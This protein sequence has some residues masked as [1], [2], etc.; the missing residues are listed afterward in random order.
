MDEGIDDGIGEGMDEGG[1]SEALPL[2]E[3]VRV[4]VRVRVSANPN[5]N[6]NEV[7]LQDGARWRSKPSR[8]G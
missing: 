5:P 6:P 2:Q 4:R 3:L 1:V 8:P 7:L